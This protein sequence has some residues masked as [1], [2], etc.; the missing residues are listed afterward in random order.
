MAKK[1]K[2]FNLSL[3]MYDILKKEESS[4]IRKN[5]LQYFGYVIEQEGIKDKEGIFSFLINLINPKLSSDIR[6]YWWSLIEIIT[7]NSS[8]FGLEENFKDILKLEKVI[9]EL[10]DLDKYENQ[11]QR[12]IWNVLTSASKL[13][14][15]LDIGLISKFVD[16]N[17]LE[18][19]PMLR[20][21]VYASKVS[22]NDF[23]EDL[24]LKIYQLNSKFNFKEKAA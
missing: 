9:K 18:K 4:L 23:D 15:R 10:K 21:F 8:R 24:L 7:L 12:S 16:S 5:L 6:F 1:Q 22:Q 20:C 3:K 17:G 13:D 19:I 2:N 11:V 14:F